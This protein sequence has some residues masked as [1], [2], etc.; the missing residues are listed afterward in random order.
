MLDKN[1][2]GSSSHAQHKNIKSVGL[3]LGSS[4]KWAAIF[5]TAALA[6]GVLLIVFVINNPPKNSHTNSSSLLD[7]QKP[8]R[9]CDS[10]NIKSVEEVL[11]EK[12][13]RIAGQFDDRTEP[14]LLS[15]CLYR[16]LKRPSRA[17]TVTIK[18]TR[19]EEGSKQA[20]IVNSRRAETETI[21]GLADEAQ[22]TTP[23]RQLT[24]RDRNR[25]TTI[26][27]SPP[28]KSSEKDSRDATI[29]LFRSAE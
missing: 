4:K 18:E 21:K 16:T 13:E 20:M 12:A 26:T 11:G 6:V 19:D 9:A 24:V 29:E 23:A 17:V 27:V 14:N 5:A 8:S 28:T 25:I 2:K 1:K 10:V 7:G 15:T 3:S 22:Y